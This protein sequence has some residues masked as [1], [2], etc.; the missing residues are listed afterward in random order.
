[1]GSCPLKGHC[2]VLQMVSVHFNVGHCHR[3]SFFETVTFSG[4]GTVESLSQEHTMQYPPCAYLS[5]P[6]IKWQR[7]YL[8]WRLLFPGSINDDE[9]TFRETENHNATDEDGETLSTNM[10]SM[11]QFPYG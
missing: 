2:L 4:S 3:K 9:F 6:M 5:F 10:A 8:E 11:L 1:M 7:I